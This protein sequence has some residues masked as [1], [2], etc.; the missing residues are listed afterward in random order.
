[1]LLLALVAVLVLKSID[2]EIIRT[3][4]VISFSVFSRG[5]RD[6]A[7]KKEVLMEKMKGLYDQY[8]A[9]IMAWYNGL[10][11][12]YQYGVMFL[13]MVIVFVIV[14]YFILVRITK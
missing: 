11:D 13:V 3:V 10:E 5:F 7:D 9:Q 1:M 2:K 6:E 8:F 14:A 4:Q 12:A